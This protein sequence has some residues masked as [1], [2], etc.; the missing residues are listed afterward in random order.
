M[1]TATQPLTWTER[2]GLALAGAFEWVATVAPLMLLRCLLGD[3]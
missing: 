2:L 1:K 3:E